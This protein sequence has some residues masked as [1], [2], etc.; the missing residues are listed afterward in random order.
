MSDKECYICCDNT[1]SDNLNCYTCDKN[2][3]I[4]CCNNL[5]NKSYIYFDDRNEIFIKYKCPYCREYNNKNFKLFNKK[6]GTAFFINLV[7]EYIKIKHNNESY[8]NYIEVLKKNKAELNNEIQK[9]EKALKNVIDINSSN[10][11]EFN[12]IIDR[13]QKII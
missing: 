7:K 4:S 8:K 6:E 2:I 10:I 13:Y 5:D 3:C 9:K 1:I 11:L 12:K